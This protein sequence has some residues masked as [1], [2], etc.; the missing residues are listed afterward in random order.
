[1]T[2]I[3]NQ[4]EQVCD[5]MI[6]QQNTTI[7]KQGEI[8]AELY[9]RAQA[10]IFKALANSFKYPKDVIAFKRAFEDLQKAIAKAPNNEA[11]KEY[12]RARDLAQKYE[13]LEYGLLD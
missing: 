3:F 5:K 1:M 7:T 9:I 11:R 6:E 2:A 8:P 10:Y 12:E 13:D 4:I